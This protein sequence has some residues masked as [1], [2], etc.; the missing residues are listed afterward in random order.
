MAHRP[1]TFV[2]CTPHMHGDDIA[3]FQRDLNHRLHAWGVHHNIKPDGVYGPK[4]RHATKTV[5]YGL[6]VEQALIEHGV[7]PYVR[8]LVRHPK[9]R[10][11][12][13]HQRARARADWRKRLVK[14]YQRSGPDLFASYLHSMLGVAEDPPGSNLGTHITEWEKLTGYNPPPGVYWCGCLQ[15]AALVAAGLPAQSWMGYCPSIEAHARAGI[16]GWKWHPADA[17]PKK[18]W[19]ALFDE[20]GIAGHVEGVVADGWPLRTIGGNTSQGDGSP[21]NGGGVYHHN[22]STYRGLPL[23]GFAEPPYHG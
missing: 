15:N 18:G 2:L 21:N 1:R 6:G 23:R 14:R 22:F 19:L 7:T 5:L 20:G 3:R 17:T 9:R 8:V 16:D 11:R 13:Q 4:T 12:R 10:T